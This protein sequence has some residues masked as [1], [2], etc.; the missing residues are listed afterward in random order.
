MAD[1]YNRLHR[2]GHAISCECWH[3]GKLAG[4]LYGVSIGRVFFGESMFSRK[5]DAS[6]VALVRLAE[7][8]EKRRFR[9]ID[10]QVHSGHLETLGARPMP[11]DTFI[12]ILKHYC[13]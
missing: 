4:G 13:A 6:K 1:A 9:L 7:M 10:C 12:G 5:A 11:R 2:L 3:E 8:L